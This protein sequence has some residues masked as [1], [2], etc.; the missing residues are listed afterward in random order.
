MQPFCAESVYAPLARGCVQPPEIGA[1]EPTLLVPLRYEVQHLLV[2]TFVSATEAVTEHAQ[3]ARVVEGGQTRGV[4][5]V[6]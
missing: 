1:G 5:V 6:R 2:G 3:D 4:D